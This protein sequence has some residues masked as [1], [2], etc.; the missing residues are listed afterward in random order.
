MVWGFPVVPV[1]FVGAAA[2]VALRQIVSSPLDSGIGI[3]LVAAGFPVYFLWT[4]YARR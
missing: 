1:V 2:A 4:R 3:G